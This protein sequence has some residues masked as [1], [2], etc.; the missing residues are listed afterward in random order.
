MRA[1]R[2]SEPETV[3]R[4]SYPDILWL[5]RLRWF[6]I[7]GVA[8][9]LGAAVS[10]R[11]L[12]SGLP[13]LVIVGVMAVFNLYLWLR[14]RKQAAGK[15]EDQSGGLVVPQLLFDLV[16][17]TLLLH[18]SGG[19][20][21]PFVLF[22]AFHVAIGAVFLP[23][24]TVWLMG[25]VAALLH[26]GMVLGEF[27]EFLPHYSLTFTEPL[28]LPP[29]PHRTPHD[30]HQMLEFIASYLCAFNLMLAGVIYLVQTVAEHQRLTEQLRQEHEKVALT[31]ERLARVGEISAGVAHTIR[32]PLHGVI[33]ALEIVQKKRFNTDARVEEMF[34]LMGE[35]LARIEKVTTR[36]LFLTHDSPLKFVKTDIDALVQEASRFMETQLHKRRIGLVVEPATL[37]AIPLDPDGIFEA[38]VNL[39]DNALA[40]C[41]EGDT[42]TVSAL[43]SQNPRNGICI[44]VADTG[45]GIP[46]HDLDRVFN[47]F[48]T[49]KPV[50]EGSGL[51]LAITSR[52]VEAHGGKLRM[53][54]QVGKGT[55]V[56]IF[57]PDNPGEG[58][59]E[60]VVQ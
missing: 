36:L 20:E 53:E 5:V 44:R 2:E 32:N 12:E 3:P 43:R 11:V 7:A 8:L 54:S 24:R 37:P 56:E 22:Y 41:R 47:P 48:F 28:G 46:A 25:L 35:G 57:I 49:T 26:S 9:A 58:M 29:H 30:M 60:E 59:A 42:V 51:G 18:F 27:F 19:A 6:A 40:A 13:I 52:I 38:L 50:G 4:R 16:S 33:N 1:E 23:R 15:V 10:L 31:R 55:R 14:F 39:L 17:L 34:D 45:V 21:N